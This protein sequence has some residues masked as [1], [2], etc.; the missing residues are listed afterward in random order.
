[1]LIVERG[2][3]KQVNSSL[4]PHIKPKAIFIEYIHMINWSLV[5]DSHVQL[6]MEVN[7]KD[8]FLP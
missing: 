1:M 5:F 8:S 3:D 6:G 4:K 7:R 2:L